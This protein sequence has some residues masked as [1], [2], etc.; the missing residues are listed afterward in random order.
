MKKL[1]LVTLPDPRIREKSIPV[2]EITPSLRELVEGMVGVL[3]SKP[4][5]GLAAPQVGYNIRLV[6]IESKETKDEEG[7]ILYEEIPLMVLINPEITQR[8]K[9]KIEIDEGCFSVPNKYGPVVRPK[10]IKAEATDLNGKKIKIN[11]SGL[12]ARVIQHEVDHLDGI[13]FIDLVDDPK[14]IR[15]IESEK[16]IA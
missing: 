13:L 8:S 12:L 16:E 10:K 2:E 9:E 7:N 6:I 14:K 15:Y 3:R 5:L 11:A 4:G 1:T